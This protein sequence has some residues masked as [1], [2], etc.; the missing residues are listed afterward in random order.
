MMK[1][2]LILLVVLTLV[3]CS[4]ATST[5][6][7]TLAPTST[8]FSTD[9]PNSTP[10]PRPSPTWTKTPTV[11]PTPTDTPTPIPTLPDKQ[12]KALF[13]SGFTLVEKQDFLDHPWEYEDQRIALRGEIYK[14]E[15]EGWTVHFW[16]STWA[17]SDFVDVL[18]ASSYQDANGDI[19][20]LGLG[21]GPLG[22]DSGFHRGYAYYAYG[23]T[24]KNKDYGLN[25]GL[26]DGFMST[27][28]PPDP[29]LTSNGGPVPGCIVR[30][31][32][33]RLLQMQRDGTWVEVPMFVGVQADGSCP[34]GFHRRSGKSYEPGKECERDGY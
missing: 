28:A 4:T 10:T 17:S 3:G 19:R 34:K 27:E 15:D 2:G 12:E 29:C 6:E 9:A 7:P 5:P 1:R 16:V 13:L 32:D 26:C 21:F 22:S 25:Y 8:T 18:L 31:S 14:I 23:T 33:G 30:K 24:C 20:D 11:T